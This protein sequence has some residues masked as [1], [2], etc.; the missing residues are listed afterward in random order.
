VCEFCGWGILEGAFAGLVAAVTFGLIQWRVAIF[1]EQRARDRQITS[2]RTNV[3]ATFKQFEP[4]RVPEHL[5]VSDEVFRYGL[6]EIHM[7]G[8]EAVALHRSSALSAEQLAGLQSVLNGINT[9]YE[10]LR[11]A[12]V[13]VLPLSACRAFYVGFHDLK[14][15]DLP[16]QPPWET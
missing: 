12:R 10:H 6:V 8:L 15:L 13:R 9:A 3:I 7:R 1:R 5:S 2:L 4:V 14:W 16:P 11:F